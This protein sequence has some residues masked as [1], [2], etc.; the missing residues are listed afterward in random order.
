MFKTGD[1]HKLSFLGIDLAG[2]YYALTADPE[3][4]LLLHSVHFS[5]TEESSDFWQHV[6]ESLC[7]TNSN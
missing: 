4:T 6:G 5:E 7:T 3:V 2:I 1:E